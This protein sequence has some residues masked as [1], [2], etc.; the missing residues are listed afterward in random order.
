M[1]FRFAFFTISREPLNQ[2]WKVVTPF[3]RMQRFNLSGQADRP[4]MG[5]STHGTCPLSE[6]GP[7]ICL[8]HIGTTNLKNEG[9]PDAGPLAQQQCAQQQC[10]HPSHEAAEMPYVPINRLADWVVTI[11]TTA[12]VAILRLNSFPEYSVINAIINAGYMSET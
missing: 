8:T 3:H 12:T 6:Y 9:G 7:P 4:G 5:G 1:A 10:H 11:I 2:P